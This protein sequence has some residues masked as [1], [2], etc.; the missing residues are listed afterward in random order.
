[1]PK[2]VKPSE[3]RVSGTITLPISVWAKVNVDCGEIPVSR[4]LGNIVCDYVKGGK[5]DAITSNR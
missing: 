2:I 4:Y 5:V 1:M 3:K